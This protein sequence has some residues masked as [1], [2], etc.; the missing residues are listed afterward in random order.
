MQTDWEELT[1]T[2]ERIASSGVAGSSERMIRDN[3]SNL[4]SWGQREGHYDVLM[5]QMMDLHAVWRGTQVTS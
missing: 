4:H 5:A 3:S 2:V 1:S